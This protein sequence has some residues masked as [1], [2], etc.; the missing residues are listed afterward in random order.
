MKVE[1]LK[2]YSP[3]VFLAG[4]ILSFADP[5]TDILTLVEFYR[6]DR[7]IWF[8]VALAFVILP[9]LVFPIVQIV[10]GMH[11]E[12]PFS[13]TRI[14][15]L[16]LHPFSAAL[17]RLEGFAF[18][19]KKCGRGDDEN[20]AQIIEKGDTL[21]FYIYILVLFQSV[22]E[23]APQFIIQLYAINTQQE[24]V[25]IIQMISLPVSFLSLNW[26]FV[27]IDEILWFEER[28][29]GDLTLRRKIFIFLTHFF[30]LSSR[31]FAVCYFKNSRLYASRIHDK[32]ALR[33]EGTASNY[34]WSVYRTTL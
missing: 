16:G 32:K 22:L 13:C 27:M 5:I 24:L 20:D 1:D 25:Q 21:F 2:W 29:C 15:A 10:R 28:E 18:S 34:T 4:A 11:E 3:F 31:L 33:S 7:K 23:S 14:I 26:A 17:A 6:N 9:C 19:L 12:R 30:L 8:G